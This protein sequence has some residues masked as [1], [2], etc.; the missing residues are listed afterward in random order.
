MEKGGLIKAHP[1]P[2]RG[3]T[4]VREAGAGNDSSGD[5]RITDDSNRRTRLDAAILV[6]TMLSL[7]MIG[8]A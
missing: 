7:L 5:D 8:Q 1:P 3:E 2:P 6:V 4:G